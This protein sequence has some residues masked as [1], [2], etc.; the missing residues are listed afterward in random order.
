MGVL[1]LVMQSYTERAGSE[2]DHE[3]RTVV[4]AQVGAKRRE[5]GEDELRQST[6]AADDVATHSSLHLHRSCMLNGQA[7]PY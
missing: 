3:T 6:P 4:S 1:H 5:T 2:E 7:P